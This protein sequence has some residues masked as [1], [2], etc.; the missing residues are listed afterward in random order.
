MKSGL[1]PR[2]YMAKILLGDQEWKKIMMKVKERKVKCTCVKKHLHSSMHI[3]Q[4]S[5]NL[6][7]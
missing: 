6:L 7:Y 4:L 1:L 3:I 2:N 5:F